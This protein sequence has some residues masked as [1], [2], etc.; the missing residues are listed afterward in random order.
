MSAELWADYVGRWVVVLFGD[1]VLHGRLT[2]IRT[3]SLGPIAL[4]F[5]ARTVAKTAGCF[6]ARA[7]GTLEAC[8][9]PCSQ[10]A[11]WVAILTG[12]QGLGSEPLGWRRDRPPPVETALGPESGGD[13]A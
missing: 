1:H 11:P 3:S 7:R 13:G 4:L 5:P 8:W 12:A 2:G 6:D 9:L 10:H